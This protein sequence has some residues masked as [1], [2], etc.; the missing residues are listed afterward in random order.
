METP[1]Y[2]ILILSRFCG[3][4]H[5][6][7]ES[8]ATVFKTSQ[9]IVVDLRPIAEFTTNEV[10]AYLILSGYQLGFVGSDPCWLMTTEQPKE[11]DK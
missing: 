2:K 3:E 9:D 4:F 5:P 1:D 6:A 10:S 7:D 8:T 11:L